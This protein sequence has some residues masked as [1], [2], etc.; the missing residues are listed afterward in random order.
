MREFKFSATPYSG[1]TDLIIKVPILAM[2]PLFLAA[3]FFGNPFFSVLWYIFPV[4]W[5]WT[6]ISIFVLIKLVKITV[7]NYEVKIYY[8]GRLKYSTSIS[9][10]KY[11][12]G[13]DS[14]YGSGYEKLILVFSDKSF[15]FSKK[16]NKFQTRLLKLDA[17]IELL[18]ELM[19]KY[20]FIKKPFIEE[21]HEDNDIFIYTNPH[22]N[23]S[24]SDQNRYNK[25]ER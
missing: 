15:T 18:M 11:V 23:P 20:G 3:F 21:P 7:D 16:I 6:I 22:Y 4:V 9:N 24:I 25:K 19:N 1:K 5:L 12:E 14:I 13:P 17:R 8:Y 10:L 2:I